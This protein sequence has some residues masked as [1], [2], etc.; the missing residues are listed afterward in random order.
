M[1]NKEI[2]DK[3]KQVEYYLSKIFNVSEDDVSINCMVSNNIIID[4]LEFNIN[5]VSFILSKAN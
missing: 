3:I 1:E 2:K 4:T 5:N